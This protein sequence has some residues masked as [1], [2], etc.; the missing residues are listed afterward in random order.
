MER[1]TTHSTSLSLSCSSSELDHQ[2][3]SENSH[4]KKTKSRSRRLL[5]F[6]PLPFFFSSFFRY[7]L[8]VLVSVLH[9]T[10]L[11]SCPSIP[12]PLRLDNLFLVARVRFFSFLLSPFL[13]N[14]LSPSHLSLHPNNLPPLKKRQEAFSS[15][16]SNPPS[17]P[18]PSPLSLSLSLCSCSL[19]P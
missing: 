15:S 3:N 12:F 8:L 13:F 6:F 10:L 14:D 9:L 2:V 5:G 4:Q 18:L 17:P 7:V 19:P 11:F 1:T 16:R